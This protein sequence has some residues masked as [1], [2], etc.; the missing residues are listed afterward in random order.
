MSEDEF[1]RNIIQDLHL[2]IMEHDV[3]LEDLEDYLFD[4]LDL[5]MIDEELVGG[6]QNIGS[7]E[8][9]A[10]SIHEVILDLNQ[11]N[12]KKIEYFEEKIYKQVKS[13]KGGDIIVKGNESESG[14]GSENS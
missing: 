3:S 7:V 1:M 14:S 11:G 5:L 10:K 12:S 8:H 6:S 9:I 13:M 4:I 2:F